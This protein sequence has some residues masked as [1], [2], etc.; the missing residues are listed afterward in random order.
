MIKVCV[1]SE[2]LAAVL[3]GSKP[4]SQPVG[5]LVD[6]N[7]NWHTMFVSTERETQDIRF[8]KRDRVVLNARLQKRANE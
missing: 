8:D 2:T 7:G 5:A 3:D 6:N 1:D 4:K